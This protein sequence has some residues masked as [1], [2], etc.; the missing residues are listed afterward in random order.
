M[1][2]E[3]SYNNVGLN[4]IGMPK[5]AIFFSIILL[6]SAFSNSYAFTGGDLVA[7]NFVQEKYDNFDSGIV[8]IPSDFFTQNNYKRYVIF[9]TGSSDLEILKK[10]SLYGIESNN[11]FFHVAV[12]EENSV[13]NLI[14][15]GY[16]V[17]EDFKLDFHSQDEILDAS[18]IGHITGSSLAETKYNVT[19]DGITVAIVD[20]GVDFSNP[21]I[22]DSLARDDLNHPIMVDADGQGII[23]TNATFFAYVDKD[24]IIRNYTK[25]LPEGFTS[26]VYYNKEGVFLDISQGGTGTKIPIYNSFFGQAGP[27]I[28]FNG[29]LT[30]DMKIGDNNRDYIK[31]KSGVYH[32]GIMYQGS[33]S[34]Q[35]RIQVVPVLFV[36]SNIAGEYDTII[37]D[38]STSWE[39]YTRS[40]L[41]AGET[42]NY[43][44]DFTDEKP[45][46]LGSGNE[47][48]VY[49]SNDDGKID[50]TAG[51]I[52]AQVLD[53]YNVINNKT[54]NID[55]SVN[56]IN[57]TL[58]P[59]IDPNGEFFG[60]MKTLW[61]MGQQVL[62]QFHPKAYKNMIFTITQ[63]S[64]S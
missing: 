16:S 49:D 41:P 35:V 51:T 32:L 37:A 23:L 56:A 60:V 17:I 47:F 6:S 13:S 31:S 63:K 24:D 30:T 46:V 15:R 4:N 18:R 1:H 2:E 58:L 33:F 59:P 40:D 39:D 27:Q 42:P 10:N 64:M 19:G 62:H 61:V 36:D 45:I 25:T 11:G 14:A 21:D 53:V 9:G 44:F 43:D 55:D 52:G 50:Y 7:N 5:A 54:I 26:G 3:D 28:V 8:D 57:G 20:T 48:L 38:L 29:T 34:G 22:K 12:L